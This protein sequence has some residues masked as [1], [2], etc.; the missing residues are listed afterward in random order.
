MNAE[1]PGFRASASNGREDEQNRRNDKM[2]KLEFAGRTVEITPE[3]YYVLMV[4]ASDRMLSC[5]QNMD[6]ASSQEDFEYWR[7]E[8]DSPVYLHPEA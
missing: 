4:S 8:R 3:D 1:M 2:G 5:Q 7:K 6:M